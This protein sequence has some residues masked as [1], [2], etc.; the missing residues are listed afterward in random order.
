MTL[1]SH[2][3]LNKAQRSI[4]SRAYNDQENIQNCSDLFKTLPMIDNGVWTE[5]RLCHQETIEN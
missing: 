5:G 2:Q 1:S 3:K 4:T